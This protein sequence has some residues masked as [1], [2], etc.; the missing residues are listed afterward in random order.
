LKKAINLYGVLKAFFVHK[1]GLGVPSAQ[2][3]RV[4]RHYTESNPGC[5]R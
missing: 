5:G 2:N 4:E 1:S 3:P